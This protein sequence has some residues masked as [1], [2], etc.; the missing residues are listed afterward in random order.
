MPGARCVPAG[1][2]LLLACVVSQTARAE[3]CQGNTGQMTINFQNI[4]YLPTLRVNTQMSSTMPD[5]G[6]GIRFTCDQQAPIS[7][8]KTI[9]FRPSGTQ[10]AKEING[11]AVFSSATPGIGYSLS[12]QC[13]GGPIKSLE[14]ASSPSVEICNSATLPAMLSQREIIVKAFVTF[15]KTGNIQ[16]ISNNHTFANALANVGNLSLDYARS[17]GNGTQHTSPVTLD[18]AAM[19]VDIGSSGSCS[20]TT[21]SIPVDLGNV[22]RRAF[23]GVGRTAGSAVPFSIP[24]YCTTPTDIRIGFFGTPAT[25]GVTDTLEITHYPGSADGVGVKISYGDNGSSAPAKGTPIRLNEAANLPVVQR[26]TASSASAAVPVHYYA[27]YVQT[28]S[29]VTAGRG[30]STATFVLEYN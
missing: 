25:T 5:N 24:V 23:K 3:N 10:G 21:G 8:S 11:H 15:Y 29:T 17:A 14:H 20:V 16:L 12:F 22:N 28:G 7:T 13:D 30:N 18:L 6:G 26:I 4:K 1:L 2:L 19:N 9:V 27:Q